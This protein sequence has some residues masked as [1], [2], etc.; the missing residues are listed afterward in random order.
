MNPLARITRHEPVAGTA[1]DTATQTHA[2]AVVALPGA[3]NSATLL[4][5]VYY[6]YSGSGTLA[7]ANL[8]VADGAATVFSL[9]VT[10]KGPGV[11]TFDPPLI[12]GSGNSMTITLPDGGSSVVGTLSVRR[13]TTYLAPPPV[14]SLNFNLPGNSIALSLL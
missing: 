3:N 8:T 12:G 2:D 10:A 14:P 4:Y 11:V 13:D 9:P 1:A 5:A 7:T 6:C